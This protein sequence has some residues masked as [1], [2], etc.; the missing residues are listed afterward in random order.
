MNNIYSEVKNLFNTYAPPAAFS[1][2]VFPQNAE[3]VNNLA[4]KVFNQQMTLKEVKNH[5]ISEFKY[6]KLN[7]SRYMESLEMAYGKDVVEMARN[8]VVTGTYD[9]KERCSFYYYK[10]LGIVGFGESTSKDHSDLDWKGR[11]KR[12]CVLALA[13]VLGAL[14]GFF[15]GGVVGALIGGFGGLVVGM[16]FLAPEELRILNNENRFNPIL[17]EAYL[18][19]DKARIKIGQESLC[20]LIVSN[21]VSETLEY[22]KSLINAAEKSIE[23]SPN[24][25]GGEEFQKV[26]DLI[27]ARMRIKP[28]LKAHI[29]MSDDLLTEDN[30]SKLKSLEQEF[31]ERFKSLITKRIFCT[32]PF[33]HTEENHVKM[34]IVD[35]KY[36]T[37]GGAGVHKKMAT[38]D[39][40]CNNSSS[41][42]LAEQFID[43]AFRDTDLIGTG[44]VAETMR[45]QFFALFRKWERRMNNIDQDRFFSIDPSAIRASNPLEGNKKLRKD[46]K[47]KF[48]VGGPE[49]RERNPITEEYT[50]CIQQATKSVKIAN[51]LFNPTPSIKNALNQKKQEGVIR[52]G[53]FNGTGPD[54]SLQHNV[55]ALP[56]RGN[57]DLFSQVYEYQKPE[58]LY[59]KKTATFDSKT[60]IVGS[61]NLGIKS[62]Y[63]DDEVICVIENKDA[64]SDIEAGL[65]DDRLQSEEHHTVSL[66]LK[67]AAAMIPSIAASNVLGPYFG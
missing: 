51:L 25:A 11:A 35:G 38:D 23:F 20:D 52:E 30:I 34:L 59:H 19:H 21:N 43:R 28:E 36:F 55:Y 10:K 65:K 9:I 6:A 12:C 8:D 2:D 1:P 50:K 58:T 60:A 64:V 42:T 4:K 33:L 7:D 37:V 39:A 44:E 3:I 61:Y 46:V 47:I 27:E 54:S 57:Y 16:A 18:Y 24:F 45:A 31:G 41:K 14:I 62:A 13:M 32:R 56:N 29:I 15:V 48:F 22:K 63:C 66:A 26:L 49:H 53:Y 67:Q 40:E 5:L 17:P